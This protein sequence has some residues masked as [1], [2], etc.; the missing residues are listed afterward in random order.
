MPH[1]LIFAAEARAQLAT[2]SRWYEMESGSQEIARQ[3]RE[4][5]LLE[6]ESLRNN[7]LR[8]SLSA[9]NRKLGLELRELHYG[10]GRRKTHRAV[11][12]I[13]DDIVRVVAIRHHAQ[14]DLR[15]EDLPESL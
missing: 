10:S 14:R 3:W 12:L 4:G 9:E 15:R 5:F 2:I 6:L 13:V 11:Y 8:G 7:P 1:S